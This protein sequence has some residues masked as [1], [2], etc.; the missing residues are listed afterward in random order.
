MQQIKQDPQKLRDF[1]DQLRGHASYWQST[2]GQL[3][4]YMARLGNSWQDK[5]FDEFGK[6]VS[7]LKSS[8]NEFEKATRVAV[9]ELLEDAERLEEYQRIQIN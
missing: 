1:C 9:A 7:Q 3:E 6:E 2:I 8:L 5:Q 4:V